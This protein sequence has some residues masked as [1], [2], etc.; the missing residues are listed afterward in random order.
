[1]VPK[2]QSLWFNSSFQSCAHAGVALGWG[3]GTGWALRRVQSRF[4]QLIPVHPLSEPREELSL[5]SQAGEAVKKQRWNLGS[6][7]IRCKTLIDCSGAGILF[8]IWIFS[9]RQFKDAFTRRGISPSKTACLQ[10]WKCLTYVLRVCHISYQETL[11]SHSFVGRYLHWDC[12][13]AA[14]I[15]CDAAGGHFKVTTFFFFFF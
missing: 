15:D 7:P 11:W 3:G 8:L 4:T 6:T 13:K 12:D 9:V 14:G 10:F 5:S 2:H 1:M